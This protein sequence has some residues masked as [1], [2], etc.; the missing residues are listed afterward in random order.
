MSEPVCTP[1]PT[2]QPTSEPTSPSITPSIAEP[3]W[4]VSGDRPIVFL[5][6][7]ASSLE[8]AIL[9]DWIERARPEGVASSSYEAITIV[10]SRR[11]RGTK[12]G[13]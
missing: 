1:Q 4:P 13:S 8:E 9:R 5:L 2:S 6:D 11:P 10:S 12:L 3:E 7:A